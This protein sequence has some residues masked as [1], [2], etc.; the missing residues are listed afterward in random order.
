MNSTSVIGSASLGN[1][2]PDWHI[3]GTSDYNN[4]GKSDILC[5]NSSGAVAVWE[6]K[7]TSVLAAAVIANPGPT[8]LARLIRAVALV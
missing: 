2:G 6:M 8:H 3:L 1:P 7:G 5:Q 4:D